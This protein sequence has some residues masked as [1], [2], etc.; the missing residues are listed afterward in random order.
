[1]AVAAVVVRPVDTVPAV[2]LHTAAAEEGTLHIPVPVVEVVEDT[3]H[4]LNLVAEAV[5]G[6]LRK[7]ILVGRSADEMHTAAA[8][9]MIAMGQV[10]AVDVVHMTPVSAVAE[11][12][13]DDMDHVVPGLV[14]EADFAPVEVVAR[15]A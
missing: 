9:V 14:A 2:A 15:A 13:M 6:M 10:V 4:S 8:V 3:Y 1:V 12:D 5:E 11:A 7:P